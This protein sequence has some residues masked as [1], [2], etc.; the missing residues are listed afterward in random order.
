M[1]RLVLL[2]FGHFSAL[3]SAASAFT[4]P[5]FPRL[6]AV[7]IGNQ[8]YQ[9]S[10]VQ[11][12]LARGN[13]AV[14][15]AYPGWGAGTGTTL[16]QAIQKIK[17]INPN[18]LVF[19][20]L[21]DIEISTDRSGHAA[22][23]SLYAKLDSMHWYLY[24]N[25]GSG[26][27]VNSWFPGAVELNNTL[28][29]PTDANGDVWVSWYAK[30]AVQQF[31]GKRLLWT[32][33]ISTARFGN[34]ASMATTTGTE[35]PIA[36]LTQRLQRGGDRVCASISK[37]CINR[38]PAN[39]KSVMSTGVR[40]QAVF[41]E[42]NQELN[43][44]FMEGMI[45]FSWS[46]ETWGGWST[47]MQGYRKIMAALAAPKLGMFHQ[48]G[49]ASDFQSLRYGLTS[50]LMDD[51]YFVFSATESYTDAPNFDEYSADLGDAT[52]ATADIAMA[53]WRLP[54]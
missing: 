10:V 30:W 41:P 39:F 29:V 43:G 15:S 21:N 31:V 45:G 28:F 18:T 51:G 7:M 2:C 26:N 33:S 37:P 38:C 34:R 48:F 12:E 3:G 36:Q 1:R 44:G 42:L 46:F 23:A 25:G 47:M 49:S 22:F 11:Q 14:I 53:A 17:A 6:G 16:Q 40:E 52:S 8:N 24:Q 5:P 50:C 9:D 32:V 19:Q 4:S 27:I 35:R 13:I 54:P 20:Y